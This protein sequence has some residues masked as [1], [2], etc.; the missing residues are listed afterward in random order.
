MSLCKS[1]GGFFICI[2]GDELLVL[3]Y[4][5]LGNISSDKPVMKIMTCECGCN[6][7][8]IWCTFTAIDLILIDVMIV[9]EN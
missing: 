5:G 9:V 3:V 6:F 2:T 1:M 4:S 8:G 7:K